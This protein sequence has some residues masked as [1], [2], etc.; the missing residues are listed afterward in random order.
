MKHSLIR[1]GACF[2]LATMAMAEEKPD[3]VFSQWRDKVDPSVENALRYLARVQLPDGAFPGK[4]GDSTGIPALVGMAFLSK[5][6][7]PTD[8]PY[9][10]VLN[11]CIDFVLANQN[12]EG[13]FVKGDAGSG[14]MYAHNIATLFLSEVSGMSDAIRQEKIATALPKALSLILR[15]QAVK[16]DD[17]NRGGWRYSPGSRDSDTSCSGWALMA[18]RSAK[19]NGASVPDAAIA[20]AVAYL[21]RHQNATHGAFGYTNSNDPRKTLTGMGLLCLELCG[22]HGTPE[23][24]K[25]A[26]YVMKTFRDLPGQKFE[27]Y[28][29][30]Y[31]AQGTFQIGGRYWEEYAPWMYANYLKKQEADGSWDSSEAGRI[32]GTAIMA[33]TFTVPYRQL[34]IYQRDETVDETEP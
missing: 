32:Y 11:R 18:L 5:G 6:H 3:P 21:K 14:P 1:W 13:L 33:L 12:S 28:G 15:A 7:L 26:D 29:N 4:F 19:L 9:T 17:N 10:E 27:F 34:P 31:N 22:K 24:I 2:F 20:D 16:K 25:A 30:Y 23:T 8:G